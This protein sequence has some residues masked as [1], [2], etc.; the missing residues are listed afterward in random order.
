MR[1][2]IFLLFA[3]FAV[4]A[5]VSAPAAQAPL[6]TRLDRALAVPHVDPGQTAAVAI[7]LR[8]GE[9]VYERNAGRALAP[10]S[11]EKLTLSYSLLVR[12]GPAYRIKTDLLGEGTADGA[13]WNGDLVLKGYGDPTLTKWDLRSLARSV[14][15]LGIRRVTGSVLADDSYYDSRRIG[16]GWKP[17]YYIEESP[18]LSAL[19]VDRARV[20]SRTS[21]EPAL[22]AAE[23]LRSA[24]RAAGVA[25]SGGVATGRASADATRL[26]RTRSAPLASILHAVNGDSDNFTA[27]M[28]LKHLG[29]VVRGNGS[30]AAGT[31]AVMDV[32]REAGI[33]VDAV[34]L[35]D[36]SGLSLLD[37]LTVR[38][39]AELLVSAWGDPALRGIFLATLAVSGQ[40]G[41]L[42]RRLLAP[43]VAGKVFAKTGTT[44]RASALAGFVNGHYAFAVLQNGSPVSWVW[45]R[46][47]QDRFVTVLAKSG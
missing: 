36:G 32:L 1:R 38:T 42:D 23:K 19:V 16:P 20:G 39:L 35:A 6:P 3:V 18:P 9:L 15:A 8:T 43:A 37:R 12:L 45:A 33:P 29:A 28:L 25:V 40:R 22:A 31:A 10:A 14:A 11:T 41:T 47:A 17:S 4:A 5:P 27:E 30:S 13:T 46:K 7:D 44:S 2:L 24:L 26:G 21:T 34:R